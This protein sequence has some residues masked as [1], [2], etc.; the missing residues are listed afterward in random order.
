MVQSMASQTGER[1][2]SKPALLTP[3]FLTV[4]LAEL[5]YFTADGMLLPALPRSPPT[6]IQ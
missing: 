3:A 4:A 5:A 1:S 2:G 6:G